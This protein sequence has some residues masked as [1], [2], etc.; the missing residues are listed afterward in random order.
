MQLL[1]QQAGR[2]KV[3]KNKKSYTPG[4][5]SNSKR[6]MASSVSLSLWLLRLPCR[7]DILLATELHVCPDSGDVVTCHPPGCGMR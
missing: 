1:K 5:L 6:D 7:Y 3:Y 4:W 2:E